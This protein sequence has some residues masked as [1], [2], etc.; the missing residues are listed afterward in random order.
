MSEQTKI[1]VNYCRYDYSYR[2]ND[3]FTQI[4]EKYAI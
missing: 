1:C 3:I 4:L 2:Q